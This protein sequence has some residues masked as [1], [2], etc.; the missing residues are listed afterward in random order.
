MKKLLN[1]TIIYGIGAI[2]PRII[3]FILNPLYIHHINK[4][5]F[6][7][8]TNLYALISFVN[9]I[10]TF[11][12]ETA[13]FRFSSEE[14]NKEKTFNTSFWFLAGT[15]TLFLA[16]CLLFN[17]PLADAM[18]YSKNPEFIRWF[19]WIAFFDTIC[20]IPFAWLR[21]HN[22][23]IKYSLIRVL[24]SLAQTVIVV[25]LFFMDSG[26][27]F[28]KIGNDREGFLPVLE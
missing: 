20:V 21:Y 2:L 26:R 4:D 1:E 9:I 23:P 6:A 16:L 19:A 27:I 18:G 17:Q 5:E 11:G 28:K 8:F 12:F 15:S 22:K 7:Q 14:E 24:Q 13:F 3:I 10:L 25:L